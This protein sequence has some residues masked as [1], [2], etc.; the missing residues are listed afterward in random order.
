ME[1]IT[2]TDSDQLRIR[3]LPGAADAHVV[4]FTGIGHGMGAIQIDEFR[5]SLNDAFPYACS[6]VVDKQRRWYNGL[7]DDTLAGLAQAATAAPAQRFVTLGNSMGGFGAVYF[8]SRIPNC[9]TAIAF[10]PQFSV[11]PDWWP[12]G[13]TRWLEYRRD[14]GAHS[15]AHALEH[16]SDDVAYHIFFGAAEARDALHSAQ[17]RAQA[18]RRCAVYIVDRA[19][20]AV[21]A[22]IK[23]T[24]RL[25]ALLQMLLGHTDVP[26]EEVVA[27]LRAAGLSATA[28]T[29][30]R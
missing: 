6:F 2:L 22:Q 18:P 13:D 17:F 26:A 25:P 11:N 9:T 3:Y 5:R 7:Q 21:T 8:A 10:A 16:P 20:H 29:P 30:G 15:V 28:E 4:S 24:G 12:E 27:F 23:Q 1:P 19:D 14:I